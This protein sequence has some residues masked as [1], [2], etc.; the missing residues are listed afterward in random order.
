MAWLAERDK[1][2]REAVKVVAMEGFTGFKT[3]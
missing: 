2:W 3:V 1:S